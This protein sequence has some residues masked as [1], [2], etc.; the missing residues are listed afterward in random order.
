MFIFASLIY[1]YTYKMMSKGIYNPW[2]T[3]YA[4]IAF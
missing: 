1:I 3:D 4:Q 2:I